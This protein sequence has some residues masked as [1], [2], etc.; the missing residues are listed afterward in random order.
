[1]NAHV[2]LG[3]LLLTFDE[4]LRRIIEHLQ[5]GYPDR[6]LMRAV[7]TR[8]TFHVVIKHCAPEVMECIE[9]RL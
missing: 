4:S 6:A 1:M 2:D 7:K 9:R 3:N 8:E 5:K